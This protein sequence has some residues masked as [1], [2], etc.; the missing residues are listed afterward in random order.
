MPLPPLRRLVRAGSSSSTDSQQPAAGSNQAAKTAA[1]NKEGGP[2]A[3]AAPPAA[4]KV[5]KPQPQSQSQ[6][7]SQ[8]GGQ[9]IPMQPDLSAQLVGEYQEQPDEEDVDILEESQ[10]VPPTGNTQQ[11]AVTSEEA[12]GAAGTAEAAV[13]GAAEAEAP[14][15][16]VAGTPAVAGNSTAGDAANPLPSSKPPSHLCASCCGLVLSAACCGLKH[17]AMVASLLTFPK[18]RL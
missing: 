11:P 12:E 18:S 16:G 6:S 14:A 4:V 8:P 7:Q 17:L 3:A 2:A 9:V 1:A 13:N 5:L 10:A 15:P